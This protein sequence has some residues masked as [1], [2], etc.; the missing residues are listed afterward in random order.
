[1]FADTAH[2]AFHVLQTRDGIDHLPTLALFVDEP[3]QEI[4]D[5]REIL[6]ANVGVVFVQMLEVIL[7]HH[8]RL[9]DVEGDGDAV[10]VR[11]FGQLFHVFDVCAADVGVEKHGIA[12]AV[13]AFDEIVEIRADVLKCFGQA[14]LFLDGVDGEIDGRNPRVG[15]AVRYFRAQKSRVRGKVNPEIFL[16]CVVHDLVDEIWTQ[17]RLSARSRK[18][19]ARRRVQPVDCATRRVFGHTFDA[20]VIRPAVVTIEVAFPLREQVSDDRLKVPWKHPGL[21]VRK[22]P[23]VHGLQDLGNR[24]LA[25]ARANNPFVRGNILLIEIVKQFR[26]LRKHGRRQGL[27]FPQL[28]PVRRRVVRRLLQEFV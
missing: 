21:E 9:V 4:V 15:Q 2:E 23:A 10:V 28:R 3:V 5:D 8:R 13:L 14:W 12:V 16:C 6:R 25:L 17:Q 26:I 19:T 27:G 18:H 24:P 7:L 1:M 20:I 22:H 11:D